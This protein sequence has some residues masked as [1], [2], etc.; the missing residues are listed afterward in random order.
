VSVSVD[1]AVSQTVR[2]APPSLS[3]IQAPVRDGLDQV[4]AEIRRIVLSDFHMIE[5]VNHHLLFVQGKLF[6]P[7]LLLLSSRVNG[8]PTSDALTLAAV[9]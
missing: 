7:T 8:A 6:R 4:G 3:T 1:P 2:G 9:V 5:E